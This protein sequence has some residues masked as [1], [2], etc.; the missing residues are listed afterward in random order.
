MSLFFFINWGRKPLHAVKGEWQINEKSRNLLLLPGC[1]EVTSHLND[2]LALNI[3]SPI[4]LKTSL[5]KRID[6]IVSQ[7][8][9]AILAHP[10][11]LIKPYSRRKLLKLKNYQGIE[12]YSPNKIP[13]PDITKRWDFIL[14]SKWQKKYIWGFA[15]DD[16]HDLRRDAG[17]A[18]IMVRT[19]VVN[20]DS[21]LGALK[22][23]S[24]Y[25]TTGANINE[26]SAGEKVIDIRVNQL[27]K[28]KFLGFKG[29]LLSAIVSYEAQYKIKGNEV[30]VRIEIKD[31]DS[32]K[33][34]WTQPFFINNGRIE[35]NPYKGSIWLKGCIHIHTNFNG[36]T[37][38]AEEII[39]WY[40]EHGYDFL[41]IT[42]HNHIA[43]PK[44]TSK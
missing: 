26:I 40:R 19:D 17:R 20:E 11:Y 34:A 21:I 36:G 37:S 43:T 27:S 22:R 3:T 24:F 33:K 39:S 31:L 29:K 5:Q 38:P 10:S 15:S 44:T 41:A 4:N 13:W 16:M 23:G 6:Q 14:S 12:I 8:G 18:W 30:Y 25:S 28:I 42:E 9:L 35:F 7:G 2:I 32:K 1:V